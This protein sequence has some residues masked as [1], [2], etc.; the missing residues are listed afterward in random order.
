MST[1]LEFLLDDDIERTS[2]E[3][4]DGVRRVWLDVI[5]E[6][7]EDEG[8]DIDAGGVVGI[9]LSRSLLIELDVCAA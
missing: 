8:I 1:D 4:T 3:T 2:D 5:I 7:V 6:V 9:V